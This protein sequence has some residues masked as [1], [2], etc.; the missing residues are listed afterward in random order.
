MVIGGVFCEYHPDRDRF[1][2]A[3]PFGGTGIVKWLAVPLAV[4]DDFDDT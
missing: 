3:F 4:P 1:V 2:E